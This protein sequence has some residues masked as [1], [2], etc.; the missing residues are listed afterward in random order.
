LA[1]YNFI[2]KH[3]SGTSNRRADTLSRRIDYHS[4]SPE[5]SSPFLKSSQMINSA[6][7]VIEEDMKKNLLKHSIN[8]SFIQKMIAELQSEP[9]PAHLK[10]YSVF[11][12]RLL[13]FNRL[14][15][16][17]NNKQLQFQLL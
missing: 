10:Y 13:C 2:I 6:E 5:M 12:K 8:D 15:Y 7:V 9:F 17:F 4:A 11:P 3:V 16:V 14:I 1:G